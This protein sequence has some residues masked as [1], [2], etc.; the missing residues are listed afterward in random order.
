MEFPKVEWE[1]EPLAVR[2]SPVDPAPSLDSGEYMLKIFK[3]F[4]FDK[5]QS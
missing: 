2:S 3:T 5:A 4:L 1:S